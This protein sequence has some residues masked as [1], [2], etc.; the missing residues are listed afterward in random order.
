M[1]PAKNSCAGMTRV[2]RT[3][4]AT[5]SA[6]SAAATVHHS[7]AGSACS[8]AAAKGAARADGRMRNVAH[9]GRQQLCPRGLP[10]PGDGRPNAERMRRCRADRRRSA[11]RRS[12][13]TPL[14]S[15]RWAGRDNRN[16]MIGTRL[17]PPA[18][19][20]PSSGATSASRLTASSIVCGAW[21][22]KGA[23]FIL[24]L[25]QPLQHRSIRQ[26]ADFPPADF[27]PRS[28]GGSSDTCIFRR[29]K[30]KG[31]AGRL[32]PGMHGA[33]HL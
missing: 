13:S 30:R 10:P 19:I 6:P 2:P 7:E 12:A 26:C 27:A 3:L 5:I 9:H 28:A 25:C 21:Y 24:D 8:D 14:M 29:V 32:E 18:R 20:R 16:A 17:W 11:R 23:T 4:C 1:I 33:M 31:R 22:R 15:T